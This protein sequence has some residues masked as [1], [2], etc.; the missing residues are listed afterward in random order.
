MK[1]KHLFLLCGLFLFAGMMGCEDMEDN[2]KQYLKEY[3]YSSKIASVRCYLGFER[4]ALAWDVPKDQKAKQ[5]LIEYGTD[6]QQKTYDHLVDSVIID[7]LDDGT[8][9]E[10]AVYTLDN[11]GN[12]SVPC[13][14]TAMPISQTV[15]DNLVPPTCSY[16]MQ[17]GTPSVT[18]SALSTVSMSYCKHSYIRYKIETEDGSEVLK[19]GTVEN[20]YGNENEALNAVN[21]YALPV[22]ELQSGSRYYVDFTA[23]VY[24]IQNNVVTMDSVPVSARSRIVVE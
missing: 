22:P 16:R 7:G 18:F 4:V 1:Q 10:F 2:Y 20:E 3:N 21:E 6:K 8:G 9:Y 23:Y 15:V 19:E 24:P 17:D 5:I 11:A 13:N 12:R 14:V